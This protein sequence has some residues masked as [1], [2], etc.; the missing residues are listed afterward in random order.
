MGQ[1]RHLLAILARA[2]LRWRIAWRTIVSIALPIFIME[3]SIAL[4]A[5]RGFTQIGSLGFV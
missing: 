1:S 5:R 2:R 3:A 4:N